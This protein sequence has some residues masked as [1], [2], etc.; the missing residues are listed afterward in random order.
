MTLSQ[1]G[2]FEHGTAGFTVRIQLGPASIG[3]AWATEVNIKVRRPTEEDYGID[4]N[5][6]VESIID[7]V[8]GII[9]WP[10]VDG[11]I[12]VEGNYELV[13]TVTGPSITLVVD[14]TMKVT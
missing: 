7:E 4:K 14:G 8:V 2:T 12:P 11:D 3:I 9:G 1:T 10:L 6:G 13:V 5:L